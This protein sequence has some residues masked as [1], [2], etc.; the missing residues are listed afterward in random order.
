MTWFILKQTEVVQISVNIFVNGHDPKL[1]TAQ[2]I[3]SHTANMREC[4]VRHKTPTIPVD[5]AFRRVLTRLQD[6]NR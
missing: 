5:I 3:G 1:N 4:A 2:T 6:N